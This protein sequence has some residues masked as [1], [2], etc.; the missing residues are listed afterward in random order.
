[1]GL[2]GDAV[3]PSLERPVA[4]APARRAVNPREYV[5][6]SGGILI[7]IAV[8]I[9]AMFVPVVIVSYGFSDDYPI[10]ALADGLGPSYSG[11][12][13]GCGGF[14]NSVLDTVAASGRPFAGLLD[15]LFFSAAGTIDN[16]RFIRL[17]AIV[18]IVA[19]ALLLHWAL[20]R[21]LIKPS[22]AALIAV[23][24]CTVPAFQ[25]YS[26][27]AVLFTSPYAALLGGGA[28]LLAVAATD[29]PRSVVADRVVGA[30]AMLLMAL[31]IYQPAAMFFWVFLGVTLLGAVDE[32]KRAVRLVRTHF[33]IG[34]VALLLGFLVARLAAKVIGSA[35]L[36]PERTALT[37]DPVGKARWFFE[38][39]L[40]HS[41]NLFDLTPSWWF[42]AIVATVAALGIVLLL[43]N[44][45]VRSPLLYV[46]TAAILI[47]LSFLPNLAIAENSR[48]YRT[49]VSLSALIALYAC[50]G[51]LGIWF[52]V[53][54]WL[55]RH[56]SG[57]ALIGAE[58]LAVTVAVAFVATSAFVAARNVIT[59]VVDP[60]SMELRMIRSQVAAL[61][62]G[63]SRVVFVQTGRDQG[64]SKLATVD[65][66]G[67][68][69]SAQPWV[70]GPVVLLLLREQGRLAPKGH[71]PIVDRLPSNTTALPENEPVIDVRGLRRLR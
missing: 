64:L 27:W 7:G 67:V 68:P 26:F 46:G 18:G 36:S 20:V 44:R 29:A 60:Q 4:I 62:A 22:L 13:S 54:D 30:T 35:N 40:Y 49:Q 31:L 51:A 16:L 11:C 45:K 34:A 32:R 41:L 12:G 15:Q 6:T 55:R 69:S 17:V 50:L 57:R 59:L 58:S 23:L 65:E 33:A 66:F 3:A 63:V 37:H 61:P 56:V 10:L 48:T 8:A 52:T 28:S 1:M 38:W 5:S 19:L 42:A 70:P 47:P 53:R 43:R 71:R 39:P 14:G 25:V 2:R 24:V 9:V 21:S